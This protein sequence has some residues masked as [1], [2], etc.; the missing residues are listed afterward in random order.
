M[1]DSDGRWLLLVWLP[2]CDGFQ[3]FARIGS[4]GSLPL[5]TPSNETEYAADGSDDTVAH[6]KEFFKTAENRVDTVFEISLNSPRN[7]L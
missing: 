5:V 2:L 4:A 3:G 7:V 6:K 1:G